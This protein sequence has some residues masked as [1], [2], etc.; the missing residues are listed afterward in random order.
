M[1]A[2]TFKVSKPRFILLNGRVPVF[3]N[4]SGGL[5]SLTHPVFLKQFN[6]SGE[7]DEY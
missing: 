1:S 2:M 3:G 6:P 4:D 7:D 5:T